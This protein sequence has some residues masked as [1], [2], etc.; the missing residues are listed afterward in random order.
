[1]SMGK[2]RII[3]LRRA[4]QNGVLFPQ[5]E[6]LLPE[7]EHTL[8]ISLLRLDVPRLEVGIRTHPSV[9][10]RGE[11]ATRLVCGPLYRSPSIISRFEL[12]AR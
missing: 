9:L 10:R 12:N 6:C 11:A 7:C 2:A 3:G 1:M 5:L 8:I 4:Y